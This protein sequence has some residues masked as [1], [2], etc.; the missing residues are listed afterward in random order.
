MRILF[1]SLCLLLVGCSQIQHAKV[2]EKS[3][4]GW[5][6]CYHEVGWYEEHQCI[7]SCD[8]TVKSW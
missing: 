8:P 3:G 5:Q 1:L 2:C 6:R 4:E 7:G